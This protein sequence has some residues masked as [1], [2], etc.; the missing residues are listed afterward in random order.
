M[1]EYNLGTAR[2]KIELDA[3][4]VSR[5][6]DE[7]KRG[8]QDLKTELQSSPGVF[9][10]VAGS[11]ESMGERI[12]SVFTGAA[13]VVGAAI[14]GVTAY[15]VW[16][17]LRRVLDT[18]DAR[19]LF[20]QMGSSAEEV[21]GILE[22]LNST[23]EKSSFSY[24]D[25][26]NVAAQLQ[27]SGTALE[28]LNDQT[29]TVGD[30]AAF[31]GTEF[32]RVGELITRIGAQGRVSGR[33][34]MS[35][36]GMG[37]PIRQ[38]LA[39]GLNVTVDELNDMVSAGEVTS[40]MFHEIIADTDMVSGSMETMAD[41]TRGAW[42]T[43][44][45]GIAGAGQALLDPWFGENGDMVKF[46]QRISDII[47]QRVQPALA[48]FGEWLHTTGTQFIMGTLVPALQ[49]LGEIFTDTIVPAV[50]D[51]VEWFQRNEDTI[52]K[53]LAA[54]GPA[55]GILAALG[56]AIHIVRRAW[57]LLQA[58]T[59]IGLFFLLVSALI[60]AWQNSETFREIVIGAFEAVRS[61]LEPVIE[62][63]LGWFESLVE[64]FQGL[65]ESSG[66]MS[67]RISEAWQSILDFIEP[68]VSWFQEHVG[69]VF[70]AL[71]ELI[72]VIWEK[73]SERFSQAWDAMSLATDVALVIIRGLWDKYGEPLRQVIEVALNQMRN[74]F[75]LVWGV[76]RTVVETALAIIA[77][78]IRGIT[79]AIRGD[80]S[81]VWTE[82]K[83]IF[84]SVWQAIRRIFTLAIQYVSRT[85]S[86]VLGGI[87]RIWSSTWSRIRNTFR[88]IWAAIRGVFTGGIRTL[89]S[90][91]RGLPRRLL[92][93]LG[94][95]G[96]FLVNAGKNLI[97][98]FTRGIREGFSR[99]R[100]AVSDGMS[101]V[102][103]FLPFSPAKEGPFSGRGHSL[104]SGRT[105]I[106]DLAK[107]IQDEQRR[108]VRMALSVADSVHDAL[109]HPDMS[110]ALQ[111]TSASG[112]YGLP[113]GRGSSSGQGSTTVHSG[114][115][116]RIDK[117][118][119]LDPIQAAHMLD[120]ELGWAFRT[121]SR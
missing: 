87:S 112:S 45:A 40:D 119:A 18:E 2:G 102:R 71:G 30:L 77:S 94:N 86:N 51:A 113:G 1:S 70:E 106:E 66:T 89:T 98:G 28:D 96:R 36:A 67:E 115:N 31:S 47:F 99:A 37:I 120:E 104:Y 60:Y 22:G 84:S 33:E 25:V 65:G 11:L 83:N 88:T 105:M 19:K 55:A 53:V 75:E 116:V 6:T 76:I 50:Q 72:G 49:R 108:A 15:S 44:K 12:V 38:I 14:A 103:R 93:A 21:D 23:F 5:G 61:F 62:L 29:R 81:G 85:I 10:S 4:Q 57:V 109:M 7:A 46:L 42:E 63:F 26:Y 24:P 32:G 82:I 43:I 114:Q 90:I 101:N 58:A 68:I 92:N 121:R 118:E 73:V 107:G 79:A 35:M 95:V 110:S 41:T 64:W 8:I 17:G 48:D 20:G 56:T 34:L 91:M 59:P 80:W 52:R 9:S 3:S 78:V 74:V 97:G 39:D 100:Q 111:A 69:P 13:K 27:A 16:G 54:M 117:V